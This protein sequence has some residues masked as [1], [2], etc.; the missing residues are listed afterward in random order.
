M[1]S[2]VKGQLDSPPRNIVVHGEDDILSTLKV[3]LKTMIRNYRFNRPLIA[4]LS[5]K[6]ELYDLLL[7][8]MKMPHVHGFRLHQR[9]LIMA[10]AI[11][12]GTFWP[13]IMHY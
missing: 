12:R 3:G 10:A 1:L 13:N 7:L 5:F 9:H 4:L 6:A 2:F 11:Y 8:D